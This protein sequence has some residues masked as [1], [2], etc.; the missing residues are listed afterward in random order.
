[1]LPGD[2]DQVDGYRPNLTEQQCDW[3]GT[4]TSTTCGDSAGWVPG[5]HEYHVS[6]YPW[7][8]REP[9]TMSRTT[10][11]NSQQSNWHCG[12]DLVGPYP[13]TRVPMYPG[14]WY[15]CTRVD[16]PV[17]TGTTTSSSSTTGT[18]STTSTTSTSRVPLYSGMAG[19][20]LGT[21]GMYGIAVNTIVPGNVN[22]AFTMSTRLVTSWRLTW[23]Q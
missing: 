13:G 8:T 9:G 10:A 18:T 15:T 19:I 14:T 12:R 17:G 20:V 23:T 5:Y 21:Q 16:L 22:L 4:S 1:M 7:Y 3:W 2:P 6:G 11:N